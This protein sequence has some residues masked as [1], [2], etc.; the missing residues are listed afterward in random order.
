MIIQPRVRR[1][2]LLQSSPHNLQ[3]FGGGPDSLVR[4][5]IDPKPSVG[6]LFQLKSARARRQ[7][8]ANLLAID[9]D[10]IAFNMARAYV[11]E[12]LSR[13]SWHQA[14]QLRQVV[15]LRT[16]HTIGFA[17]TCLPICQY[18]AMVTLQHVVH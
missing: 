17:S 12:D 15:T 7:Q 18:S 14:L 8:I 13:S 11:L 10:E 16:E 2:P 1:S 5:A 6:H 3:H 9:L 4:Q